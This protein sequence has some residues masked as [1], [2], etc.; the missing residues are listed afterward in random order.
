MRLGK[1]TSSESHLQYHC[2]VYSAHEVDIA[3]RPDDY[4]LGNY[5]AVPLKDGRVLVGIIYDTRLYNPDF[6]AFGPRLS[7]EHELRVFSPDYMADIRTLVD[8]IVVGYLGA[9][10]SP[11]HDAP[12]V[13]PEANTE[14]YLMDD[15]Q[16][17]AFHRA[18]DEVRLGYLP[19]L[20]ALA[21]T[22]PVMTQTILRVLQRLQQVFPDGPASLR[23]RL[24]RQN[25]SWQFRVLSMP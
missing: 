24:V 1:I 19:L 20:I 22:T 17:R 6:G 11:D 21:R 25:L 13:A 10:A 4:G 5:V 2:Q 23:L 3:P 8:I 18:G 7:S 12:Q 15:H 14:V 16:V 9:D